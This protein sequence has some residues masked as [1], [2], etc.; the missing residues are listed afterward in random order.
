MG[1]PVPGCLRVDEVTQDLPDKL[2]NAWDGADIFSE[3]PSEVGRWALFCS[4]KVFELA[5]AERW[6]NCGFQPLHY[7]AP[8]HKCYL[9]HE[10]VL[11]LSEL[12]ERYT[13]QLR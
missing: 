1:M 13:R 12:M 6:T 9:E 4:E 5:R 2:T 11:P 3:P 10:A 7:F 8:F